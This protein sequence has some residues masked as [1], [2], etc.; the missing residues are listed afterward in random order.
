MDKIKKF[1]D[2][3]AKRYDYSERQFDE[4]FKKILAKFHF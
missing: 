3:Q 1:W 2:K 4:A